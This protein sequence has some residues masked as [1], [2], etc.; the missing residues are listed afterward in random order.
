M[1]GRTRHLLACA[2]ALALIG[3]PAS[4]AVPAEAEG[5]WKIRGKG[6]GHG[7]GLS[8]YGTESR[9]RNGRNFRQI[10]RH[11]YTGVRIGNVKARQVRVLLDTRRRIRFRRAKHAC[12]RR[13]NPDRRFVLAGRSRVRLERPNGKVLR[14]C[15]RKGRATGPG[16]VRI[17]G[18][19][20]YRGALQARATGSTLMV[21][22]GVGIEGYVKGVVPNEMPSS[23]QR[24]ALRAQAVAARSFGLA[25]SRSG[26]FDHYA[27]TRSQVYGGRSS[28]TRSTTRAV[29]KTRRKVI[30]HNG[31]IAVAYYHSTS[32]GRTENVEHGFG[33]GGSPSPYL[34]SVNDNPDRIS[35][36][37]R[38]RVTYSNPQMRSRLSGLFQGNLRRIRVL[39]T[40]AS[41]RIVRA[42]VVGSE[43]SSVVSGE[44]LRLRLGL[45]SSWARFE[46]N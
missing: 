12:G 43:G 22:N 10:L 14:R 27:D 36:V 23:W 21:I 46:R 29:S 42:R 30:R 8:Q 40:G 2:L 13:I 17:A 24:H 20:R 38:W 15:G 16:G 19:G 25:T 39:K 45:R 3:V 9:A 32:G 1:I 26:A 18:L 5:A 7:V 4:A 11:Y 28:E 37:H 44:T 41:P 34:K 6:F 33:G 31:K 35:P